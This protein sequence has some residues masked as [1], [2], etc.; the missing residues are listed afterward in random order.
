M[1]WRDT[2]IAMTDVALVAFTPRWK[3]GLCT[4]RLTIKY[5]W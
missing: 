3:P 4:G 1:S 5:L 2:D